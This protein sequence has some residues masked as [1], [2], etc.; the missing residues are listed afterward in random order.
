M[1][2]WWLQMLV[3]VEISSSHTEDSYNKAV[4]SLAGY[5]RQTL[6]KQLD[7]RFI[8]GFV[9]CG[10]TLSVWLCDR[11]GLL[12]VEEPFDIHKVCLPNSQ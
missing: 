11:S 9:L 8:I 1:D 2:L 5:F 6:R 4:N 3:P 7:R 10:S 12:G